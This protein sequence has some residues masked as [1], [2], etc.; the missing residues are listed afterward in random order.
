MRTFTG[1]QAFQKAWGAF[2]ILESTRLSV[3]PFLCNYTT[4]VKNIYFLNCCFVDEQLRRRTLLWLEIKSLEF[5]AIFDYANIWVRTHV[6]FKI[7]FF[8]TRLYFQRNSTFHNLRIIQSITIIKYKRNRMQP[9]LAP[10]SKFM[11]HAQDLLRV[12][13]HFTSLY[14]C[15]RLLNEAKSFC[16]NAVLKF[17]NNI[18]RGDLHK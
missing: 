10:A 17:A 11:D 6:G 16:P 15:T 13:L 3:P 7:K 9:C 12:T 2:L 14:T 1:L 4:V 8:K 18:Y 5:N